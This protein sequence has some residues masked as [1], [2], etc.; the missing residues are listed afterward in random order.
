MMIKFL[1]LFF[2]VVVVVLVAARRLFSPKT[3]LM[4]IEEEEEMCFEILAE[5]AG[6]KVNQCNYHCWVRK[7]LRTY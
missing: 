4:I 5:Q 6:L 2:V 3:T 1:I 7:I